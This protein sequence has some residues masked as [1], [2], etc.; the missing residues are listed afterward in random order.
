MAWARGDVA[1]AEALVVRT[2]WVGRE[3][4]ATRGTAGADE[5]PS[6]PTAESLKAA[7]RLLDAVTQT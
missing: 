7:D 5:L 2:T 4:D 1:Y 6:K 3:A